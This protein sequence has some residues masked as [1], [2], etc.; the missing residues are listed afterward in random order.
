[1]R[2]TVG[3]KIVGGFS[4][5]LVILLVIGVVSYRNTTSFIET[6]HRVEHTHEVM[7]ILERV[8]SLLKDAQR[9][10]RGYVITG[11]EDYLEPYQEAIE[12]IDQ[13]FRALRDSTADNPKQQR[14]LDDL[15][16]LIDG[17]DVQ[18]SIRLTERSV[19]A[20]S[21]DLVDGESAGDSGQTGR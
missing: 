6:A 18:Q 10:S 1:M 7:T 12:K 3:A 4:L 5:T 13:T 2:W 20:L 15:K 8:F 9:G 16:P 17:R 11:E 19:P 14:R 21:A